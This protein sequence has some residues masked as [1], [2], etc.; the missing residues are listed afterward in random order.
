MATGR[1][2]IFFAPI[3]TPPEFSEPIKEVSARIE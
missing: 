2:R 1:R 3:A